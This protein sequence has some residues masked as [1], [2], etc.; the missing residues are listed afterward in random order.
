[1][2]LNPIYIAYF[3]ENVPNGTNIDARSDFPINIKDL[4]V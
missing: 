3:S 2:I 4:A 1:M